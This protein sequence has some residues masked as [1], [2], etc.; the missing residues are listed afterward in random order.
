MSSL[1]LTFSSTPGFAARLVAV[2]GA[3]V[4]PVVQWRNAMRNRR[5]VALLMDADSAVLRDLGLTRIDV[6]AAMSEPLWRDPSARLLVW[7][8]ERRAAARAAARDNLE[9]LAKSETGSTAA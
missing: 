7:S 6:H 1:H 4:K 2:V 9:G 8:V 3:M 5:E